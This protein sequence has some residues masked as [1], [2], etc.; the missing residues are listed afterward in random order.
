MY[1]LFFVWFTIGVGGQT[2]LDAQDLGRMARTFCHLVKDTPVYTQYNLEVYCLLRVGVFGNQVCIRDKED[3]GAF[4]PITCLPLNRV[5]KTA[6]RICPR[7]TTITTTPA[8]T[9]TFEYEDPVEP[10]VD[11]ADFPDDLEDVTT[12]AFV[13]VE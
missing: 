3:A 10:P 9:T 6:R 8:T 11:A 5:M 7:T 12:P 1:W 4:L 13:F 2:T